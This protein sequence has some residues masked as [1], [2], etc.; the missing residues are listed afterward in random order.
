M[1]YNKLQL[2]LHVEKKF[3][4]NKTQS[5]S[6]KNLEKCVKYRVNPTSSY[7]LLTT[8][9]KYLNCISIWIDDFG[10]FKTWNFIIYSQ[11]FTLR[12]QFW[13]IVI[14]GIFLPKSENNSLFPN[15]WFDFLMDR[16]SSSQTITK[17]KPKIYYAF[18]QQV[19]N[20]A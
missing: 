1:G 16:I 18:F 5:D 20:I 8:K 15:I 14:W 3:L 12:D 10:I 6:W 17:T 19:I 7:E 11:M 2:C 13:M 4:Y 9:N